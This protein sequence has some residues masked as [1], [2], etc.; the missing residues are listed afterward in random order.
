VEERGG[1]VMG[2]VV[3]SVED[4]TTGGWQ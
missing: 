3:R 2:G 1:V 4:M